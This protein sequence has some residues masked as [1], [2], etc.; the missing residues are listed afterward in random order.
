MSFEDIELW[1]PCFDRFSRWMCGQEPGQPF[2][3]AVK[4]VLE[5]AKHAR[6]ILGGMR[7]QMRHKCFSVLSHNFSNLSANKKRKE[8]KKLF[9][10]IKCYW[11]CSRRHGYLHTFIALLMC[12]PLYFWKYHYMKHNRLQPLSKFHHVSQRLRQWLWW[13]CVWFLGHLCAVDSVTRTSLFRKRQ[14]EVND[15][16][17]PLKVQMLP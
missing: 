11:I 16:E 17:K 14:L 8:K 15:S 1:A 4:S 6:D 3:A 5:C 2:Q 13:M 12:N 7:V 10:S 9:R